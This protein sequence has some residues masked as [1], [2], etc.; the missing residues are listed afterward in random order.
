L[1]SSLGYKKLDIN[2]YSYPMCILRGIL[3]L[4]GLLTTTPLLF[5]VE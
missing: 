2:E 1:E 3:S 4:L 5:G